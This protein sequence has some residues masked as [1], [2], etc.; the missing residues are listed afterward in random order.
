MDQDDRVRPGPAL[1]MDEIIQ[2][3]FKQMHSVDECKIDHSIAQNIF[4]FSG[5]KKIIAFFR[6]NGCICR[7][8]MSDF[9]FR[10]DADRLRFRFCQA[11]GFAVLHAD[12]EIMSRPKQ[13]MKLPQQ[14]VIFRNRPHGL[15]FLH[16]SQSG[17]FYLMHGN[18][19][20]TDRNGRGM[21]FE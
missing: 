12:F 19:G 11:E 18:S 9:R 5:G 15:L 7:R 8:L 17:H 14:I 20:Q 3:G 10:I 16:S 4:F 6:K 2:D 21:R 1:D 13:Q